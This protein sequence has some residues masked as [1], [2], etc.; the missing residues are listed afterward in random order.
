MRLINADALKDALGDTRDG[1]PIFRPTEFLRMDIIEKAIDEAPTVESRP[2][3][4]WE[5]IGNNLFKCTHCG[6][7]AD[8]DYLR[9]WK[10]RTCDSEFP[11]S[12]LNCGARMG[13]DN[14]EKICPI[15]SDN[16][17]KQPCVGCPDCDAEMS[18]K[19]NEL[20]LEPKKCPIC[21]H[22]LYEYC[23]MCCYEGEKVR[24]NESDHL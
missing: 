20:N 19:D 7:V 23:F 4:A 15:Y 11:N 5:F 1:E 22:D 24:K 17:V 3:G 13:G 14:E 2:Q 8:A 6:Y 16:E 18:L 10:V 21:G 9:K 12:C